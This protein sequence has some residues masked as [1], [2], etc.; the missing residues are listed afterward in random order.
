[1][2]DKENKRRRVTERERERE[3]LS[4][5]VGAGAGACESARARELAS[6]CERQ[7]S[8]AGV[9]WKKNLY[10]NTKKKHFS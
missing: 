8:L 3:Q 6:A 10:L 7:R 1:M 4:T 2:R 9:F 5:G